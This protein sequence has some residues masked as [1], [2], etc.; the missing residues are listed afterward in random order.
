VEWVTGILCYFEK[1]RHLK[2]E[3]ERKFS[4]TNPDFGL[5]WK[6]YKIWQQ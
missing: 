1:V 5:F 6:K 2:R 4:Y 3:R